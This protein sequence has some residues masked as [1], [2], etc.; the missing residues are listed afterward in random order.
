MS[1]TEAQRRQFAEEGYVVLPGLVPPAVT[2]AV[3]AFL[4]EFL[5]MDPRDPN[6]WYRPPHRPGGMVEAYQHQS[7]WDVRQ[8]PP[9]HAAFAELFGTERLW[10]SLDRACMKPPRRPAH[11][12]WDH[13]GFLHWDVDPRRWRSLPFGV[14]GVLC[15]TDTAADQGGF[16]CVPGA[17]RGL[18]E[19][20]ERERPPRG[21]R[22]ATGLEAVAIPA[23]AGDLIVWDRLLP[24]GNG[25]NVSN[26]PR[27]AQYV[28]LFP[29]AEADTRQRDRRVRQWRERRG[30]GGRA[31]PGDPRG[32][33][34][35][36]PPAELSPLGRRLLGLDSW[37]EAGP[38]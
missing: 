26:R 25:R 24:H 2:E 3:V 8:H 30:P 36:Y 9:L 12:E 34:R 4:W 35:R 19:W 6:D 23:R 38:T 37:S 15:L 17:H 27:L 32:W 33:E 22:V 1:L 29:A 20:L 11:P 31:F 7:L 28:T 5:G 18:E 10:V 16:Q 13:A 14:Q 21:S